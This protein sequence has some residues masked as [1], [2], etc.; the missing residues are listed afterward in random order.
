MRRVRMLIHQLARMRRNWARSRQEKKVKMMTSK[1]P[2]EMTAS[3]LMLTFTARSIW[4]MQKATYRS[5]YYIFA[6]CAMSSR[7]IA[8]EHNSVVRA[9][10]D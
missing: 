3:A 2:K 5:E 8:T 10:K 1:T 7:V 9:A 4:R 6:A